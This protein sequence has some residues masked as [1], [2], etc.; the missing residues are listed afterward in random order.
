MTA[1]LADR[2]DRV[3]ALDVSPAMLDR[4]R[5]SIQNVRVE[6][7]AISGER[8]DGVE[9]EVAD[10][11]VCYLVLQHLPSRETVVAYLTEFARVLAPGGEVF[12]Q[13][14]VLEPGLRARAW[15][16]TRS[17]VVPL[18]AFLGPTRRREFRGF[19]LT[20]AE[21]DSTLVRASLRV[22]AT[23]VGPDAPYRFSTDLFLRLTR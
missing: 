8:L 22:L 14:P 23:D 16:A 10:V 21:L 19:R 7:R 5:A 17:A 3:L 20:R 15:R 4:A 2:F 11:V 12:V 6:F 13:L 1:A 18:T 9:D